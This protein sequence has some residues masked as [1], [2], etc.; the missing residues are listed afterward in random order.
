[1]GALAL[2]PGIRA[3]E[4]F[5]WYAAGDLVRVFEDGYKAPMPKQDVDVFGIR[6]ETF[7]RNASLPL[8]LPFLVT[9]AISRLTHENQS[10]SFPAAAPRWN[11]VGSVPVPQNT[12]A[13]RLTH[14]TRAAP[15]R[16]PEYL[17][18]ERSLSV[19]QGRYQ[20]VWLTIAIPPGAAAGLYKGP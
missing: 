13:A 20:A 1:M 2:C 8:T 14:V 4:S 3:G 19:P 7:R 15:A 10:T 6:G 12:P 9:V 11:L 17:S 16:F 5:D 18:E